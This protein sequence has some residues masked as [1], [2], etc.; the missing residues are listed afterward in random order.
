MSV[1][2]MHPTAVPM[3]AHHRRQSS[4]FR[5]TAVTNNTTKFAPS[6][7]HPHAYGYHRRRLA[8][9]IS[10]L[11]TTYNIHSLNKSKEEIIAACD[12]DVQWSFEQE[13]GP[14]IEAYMKESEVI[15]LYVT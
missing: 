4:S 15:Y 1:A 5:T 7:S 12:R 10:P 2:T 9:P 14:T 8:S 3:P 11:S 13:Y 6:P